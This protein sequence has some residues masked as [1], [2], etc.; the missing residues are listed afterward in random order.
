MIEVDTIGRHRHQW[1]AAEARG[2]DERHFIHPG[3]RR[4]TE[5]GVVMV[6]GQR[7]YRLG[8]TRFRQLG[9][10]LDFLLSWG[11]ATTA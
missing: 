4:A 3:Q 1:Q 9:A 6:G 2:G 11:H 10:P 8:H 7:E 5:Q